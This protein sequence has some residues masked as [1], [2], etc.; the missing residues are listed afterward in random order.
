MKNSKHLTMAAIVIL[1]L[2]GFVAFAY[3]RGAISLVSGFPKINWALLQH[4]KP[5]ID[6][7]VV[8]PDS[9]A[10]EA[11]EAYL[12]N[13]EEIKGNIIADPKNEAAWNDL[14]IYRK[15][16]GDYEGAKAIWHYQLALR[17]QNLVV[18]HNLAEVYFHYDKNYPKAEQLYLEAI[19]IAPNVVINYTDLFDM[20]R[21]VYK[22]DTTAAVDIMHQAFTSVDLQPQADMRALLASYYLEKGDK[23][24]AKT[25]YLESAKAYEQ[26]KNTERAAAM[27]AEA[28]RI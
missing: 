13:L 7:E 3:S 26:V 22:Q 24:N 8:F 12:S 23:E 17:P 10:D 25:Q 20:Y 27:R 11:R 6:K 16:V 2:G 1:L 15:M 28:A 14:A 4:P 21:Y 9:F 18:L 5:T 19:R